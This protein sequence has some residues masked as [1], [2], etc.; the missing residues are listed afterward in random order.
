[1]NCNGTKFNLT[2]MPDNDLQVYKNMYVLLKLSKNEKYRS[3]DHLRCRTEV[4]AGPERINTQHSMS[5][6]LNM[7]QKTWGT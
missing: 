6:G 5:I 3:K 7:L 4:K 2:R 1:M